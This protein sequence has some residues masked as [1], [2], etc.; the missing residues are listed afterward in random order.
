ML[1]LDASAA[2]AILMDDETQ[3]YGEAV[4]GAMAG[5]DPIALSIFWFE[6][7]N[8]LT[9]NERRGRHTQE[10]SQDYLAALE[11]VTTMRLVEQ[12]PT[13]SK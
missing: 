8:A 3:A 2:L 11:A 1:V 7:R 13:S 10:Q 6:V 5:H 4:I 9:T 12:D